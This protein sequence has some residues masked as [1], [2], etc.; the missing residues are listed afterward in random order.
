MPTNPARA[1]SASDSGRVG[2]KEKKKNHWHG[3]V[4]SWYHVEGD[5]D[6]TPPLTTL[7]ESEELSPEPSQRTRNE[8]CGR[9]GVAPF[10]GDANRN[11][12]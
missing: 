5:V 10:V 8:E 12:P 11:E 4:D 3:I 7:E 6:V 1:E 9:E 2:Y